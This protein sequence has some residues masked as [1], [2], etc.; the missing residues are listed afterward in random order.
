MS[1]T[2]AKAENFILKYARPLDYELY[3]YQRGQGSQGDVLNALAAYQNADGGFGGPLEPDNFCPYSLPLTSWKAITYLRKIS[4]LDSKLA[5]VKGLV[6]YLQNSRRVDGY[7]NTTDPCSQDYP[8]APWWEDQGETQR[9]W[10]FNPSAEISSY[11]LRLGMISETEF[12]ESLLK[13]YLDSPGISMHELVNL[14]VCYADLKALKWEH[15]DRFEAKLK[16]DLENQVS[17]TPETWQGYGLRLSMFSEVMDPI[18]LS[19]YQ[20]L[21]KAEQAYLAEIQAEDGNWELNWDWSGKYTD[22]WPIAMRWWQA[23][24]A[25]QFLQFLRL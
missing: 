13:R 11:L 23:I 21:I 22:Y 9:V 8:H 12:M 19:P 14:L 7:W 10:G 1:P 16:A 2:I 4:C 25:I 6:S 5:L 3:R 15:L 17:K 24:Q 18:F 20:G